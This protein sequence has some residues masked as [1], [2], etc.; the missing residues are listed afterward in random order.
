MK[1][2]SQNVINVVVLDDHPMIRSAFEFSCA[3]SQDLVLVDACATRLEMFSVLR[4]H[5]VDVLVLDY[6]LG[7]SDVDGLILIRQLLSHFPHLKI[8]V[9]SSMEST[10][11]VQLIL[12]AGGKGFIGKSKSFN[13]IAQ[14]IRVVAEGKEFLT[15]DMRHQLAKIAEEDGEM[16]AYVQPGDADES[17]SAKMKTL[18]PREMEVLRCYLNGMS[19]SQ[20]AVKFARHIKTISGQKQGALRKLG[21]RTDAELFLFK[22]HLL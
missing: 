17:V 12:R 21:F 19:L 4:N 9:S 5:A 8:L 22:D 10:G 16:K 3:N 2:L 11:I 14:A 13:E 15:E 1:E 20:I 6:L 7:E 18:T